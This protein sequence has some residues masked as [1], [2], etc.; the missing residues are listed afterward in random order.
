[1]RPTGAD[2]VIVTGA[3]HNIFAVKVQKKKKPNT[4][5]PKIYGKTSKKSVDSEDE[6]DFI[7][8]NNSAVYAPK[9]YGLRKRTNGSRD[10]KVSFSS[11]C[12]LCA[13]HRR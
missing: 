5:K 2:S 11:Y 13:I 8:Y 3:V 1:M 10:R 9:K 12:H 4:R 6:E 7:P